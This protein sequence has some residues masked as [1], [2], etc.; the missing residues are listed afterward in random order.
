MPGQPVQCSARPVLDVLQRRREHRGGALQ[1]RPVFPLEESSEQ[2]T[3]DA[4][5]DILD[6]DG[7]VV[8]SKV[9]S[10]FEYHPTHKHWHINGVALFEIRVGSPDGPVFGGN[11]VKTTFCLID[12]YKLDDNAKTPERGYF[13]C[14]GAYQGIS[15]G[16][17]DQYQ[18]TA[19]QQLDLT[20]A[21]AGTPLYLVSTAS[22]EGVFLESDTTNNTAWVSFQVKRFSRGNPKIE[23]LG[24]SACDTPGLC[25][26]S[27][28][29]R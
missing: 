13:A 6:A 26:D 7:K 24:H 11:S 20:G 21:P 16:W 19:G 5:Q 25:G 1:L 10:Q 3:Q 27:V 15:P 18:A 28:P 22:H 8:E 23:L 14:N 4:I 17:V 12:W 2:V 29:N 9:V